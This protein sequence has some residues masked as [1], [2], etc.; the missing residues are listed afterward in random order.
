MCVCSFSLIIGIDDWDL[1]M[2]PTPPQPNPPHPTP[3]HPTPPR[4]S[5]LMLWR[6]QLLDVPIAW[7]RRQAMAWRRRQAR[8]HS[9]NWERHSINWE[10]HNINWERHNIKWKRRGGVGLAASFRIAGTVFCQVCFRYIL[11]EF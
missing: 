8:R 3:P 6:S 1:T 9:I 7:R 11:L 10:C 2:G 4:R 5:H